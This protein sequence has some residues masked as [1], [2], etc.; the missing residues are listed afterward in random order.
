MNSWFHNDVVVIAGLEGHGGCN[1][2]QGNLSSSL[3]KAQLHA[4]LNLFSK[5][6]TSRAFS[7]PSSDTVLITSF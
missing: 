3:F 4:F 7:C 6:N 5:R 1:R 2:E